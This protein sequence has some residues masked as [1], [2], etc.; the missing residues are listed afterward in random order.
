[1]PEAHDVRQERTAWLREARFGL[2]LHW[3]IYSVAGR[4][5]WVKKREHLRDEAYDRYF[6]YFQPDLFN[7]REWARQARN[8]GMRYMVVTAKHHDGFCL[9]D[10]R[11]TDYKAT[12]TPAGTDLL[13]PIL[14]AFREEGLR[15]GLYYSL[16]DWHH[17][18][19]PVDGFHPMSR[20]TA[21]IEANAGR[22]VRAYRQY[23]HAQV[24][25]LLSDYGTIDTLWFDFSY[26][27]LVWGGKGSEEW[28]S[29]ELVAK[30][31]ALQPRIVINDR[32]DLPG[33]ADV[34]TPEQ[35]QPQQAV[36]DGL[37][38]EACQTLNGS[39]G[40]DREASAWKSPEMLIGMLV[41]GVSKGGNLLLNVGPDARGRFQHEASEVLEVIGTWMQL[42]EPAIRGAGPSDWPAPTDVRYTQRGDRLYVHVLAWPFGHLH[43]PG[44]A[45]H[46]DFAR[47]LHD[48]S[49]V[50]LEVID[51]EQT[52][53]NLSMS[54]IE[55]TL[56]L[57]LPTRR[58]DVVV[59]VI[60]VWLKPPVE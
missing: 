24:E 57:R 38:W 59:P 52:A 51:P 40:Y 21:Y 34:V 42:H 12:N 54:G 32:L 60:E 48:G 20:D 35:Y 28:G 41:D 6:R 45:G 44:L 23:L 53:Q 50:G 39:W 33:S 11:L 16:L 49:E 25:E 29:A 30:A 10:S 19:F 8:A 37:L 26:K 7:P 3:G 56:T 46:V 5:E 58:P 31:R 22:D 18:E 2:F 55:G 15:V 17:P 43:L 13:R 9:W 1:M 4:H 14:D 47:F 27:D 36:G